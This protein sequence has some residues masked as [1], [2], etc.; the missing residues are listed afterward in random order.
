MRPACAV[1]ARSGCAFRPVNVQRESSLRSPG[2]Q[3]RRRDP[4]IGCSHWPHSLSRSFASDSN[5]DPSPLESY[6]ANEAS[7]QPVPHNPPSAEEIN[8]MEDADEPEFEEIDLSFQVDNVDTSELSSTGQAERDR[9][10]LPRSIK[11]L[12]KALGRKQVFTIPD[13]E[14]IEQF[15]RGRGPGGQ[16]INKTNSSV[17]LI[18]IPTGIRIQSQ[19]TRS[20]EQNRI[21]ARHILSERLDELRA[22][23]LYSPSTPPKSGMTKSVPANA[24]LTE[25]QLRNEERKAS[26]TALAD[27]YTKSELRAAKERA[28]KLNRAKKHRQKKRREEEASESD[29]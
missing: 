17:S 2:L 20:R 26:E 21:A 14:L 11:K 23:G 19:P 4:N 27:S 29:G 12:N 22:R 13:H 1:I 15:V 9:P 10:K 8:F 16:A 5:R 6:R 25:K 24:A 18:H 28:R 7:I 3:L